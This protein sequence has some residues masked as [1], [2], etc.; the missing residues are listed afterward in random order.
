MAENKNQHFI[1]QYYFKFFSNNEISINLIQ[2]SM[3]KIIRNIAIK[4]QCSK[5]Y[6]YGTSTEDKALTK[7]EGEHASL[8]NELNLINSIEMYKKMIGSINKITVNEIF[9]K[10]LEMIVF[11]YS[12]TDM[13]RKEYLNTIEKSLLKIGESHFQYKDILPTTFKF[14]RDVSLEMNEAM[15]HSDL[16]RSVHDAR[17]LLYDL[18]FYVLDNKTDIDFIFSD[19]PVI[20]YNKAYKHLENHSEINLLGFQSSGL[21]VFLPISPKKYILLI[22]EKRYKGNL[23]HKNYFEIHNKYD[24]N[25]L[26]K[27][28]LNHSFKSIY[29]SNTIEDKYIS[30]LWKQQKSNFNGSINSVVECS[31]DILH[32]YRKHMRY[33]LNLSFLESNVDKYVEH[34]FDP[35]RN[36][37]LLEI[38]KSLKTKFKEIEGKE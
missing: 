8:Q 12:R 2:K 10:I 23:L 25:S 15:L 22:D 31:D 19:A 29:F 32:I 4:N 35:Y 27:L 34:T 18:G 7:Y 17:L 33:N 24:V 26:N 11:Q 38:Y 3:G 36:K 14:E 30:K 20:F 1:P 21:L 5:N 6:F 9:L 16:I 28:Q 37:Q 13:K